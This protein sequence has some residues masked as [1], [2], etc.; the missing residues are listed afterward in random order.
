MLHRCH[1]GQF[2]LL[3]IILFFITFFANKQP[4]LL[5]CPVRGVPIPADESRR[6]LS[7]VSGHCQGANFDPVVSDGKSPWVAYIVYGCVVILY[8]KLLTVKTSADGHFYWLKTFDQSPVLSV[9]I[10][11]KGMTFFT[12]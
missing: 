3:A 2:Y 6:P 9:I 7:V 12:A 8:A 1:S 5:V 10:L 4:L 11:A